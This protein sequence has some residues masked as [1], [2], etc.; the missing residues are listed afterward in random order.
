MKWVKSVH[1]FILLYRDL[2]DLGNID[3][4]RR[5]LLSCK[6]I[7]CLFGILDRNGQK[8]GDYLESEGEKVRWQHNSTQQ[9]KG[10]PLS[11]W[12]KER[13]YTMAIKTKIM[14]NEEITFFYMDII[15]QMLYKFQGY[16]QIYNYIYLNVITSGK[17]YI[18]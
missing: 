6:L 9:N 7:V 4:I 8:Y 17:Y 3:T 13:Y 10:T 16:V 1:T 2:G 15:L 5:P 11:T 18:F 12:L 14:N